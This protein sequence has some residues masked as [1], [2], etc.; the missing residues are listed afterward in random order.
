MSPVRTFLLV[1]VLLMAGGM[2]PA[3][4]PAAATDKRCTPAAATGCGQPQCATPGHRCWT[5]GERRPYG[6]YCCN[7]QNGWYGAR[8]EVNSARQARTVLQNYFAARK[9]VIGPLRER[10]MFFEADITDASGKMI[11]RVIVHK[12]SGRIRSIL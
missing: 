11:D 12:R 4:A 10:P 7:Q 5:P 6:D 9:V 1:L 3:M 2:L 8:R